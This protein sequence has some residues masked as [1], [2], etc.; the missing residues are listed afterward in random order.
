V[1]AIRQALCSWSG[2]KDSCL[3]LHLATE[4]GFTVTALIA[5]FEEAADR[6]RS[7][8]LPESLIRAQAESLGVELLTPR[9][10]WAQYEAVFVES[11][12]QAHRRGIEHAIFGDI[13]LIPHRE[14]E[15]KVCGRAHMTAHLPLWGRPRPVVVDDVLRRGIKALCVCVNTRWLPQSFCGRPFDR[16]FIADLPVGVDPCGENGEFHTFV[17][18]APK[19]QWPVPASVSGLRSYTGPAEY[20]GEQFWFAELA[21]G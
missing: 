7:H 16:Q 15:E 2:G 11:L 4:Q 6:S 14:W 19:F 1:S 10:D 13:D 17:T 5:M 12:T 18:H 20:G 3:A 9:A 8:A 21:G